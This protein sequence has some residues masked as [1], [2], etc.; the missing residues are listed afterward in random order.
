MPKI[1]I[2]MPYYNTEKELVLPCINSVLKQKFRDFEL[3]IVNDGS[4]KEHTDMISRTAAKDSRIKLINKPNSGASSTRNVG[5]D[6]ASGDYITFVDSDDI[7]MP[8]FLDNAYKTAVEFSADVVCGGVKP[9]KNLNIKIK[10]H[11]DPFIDVYDET[12][13]SEMKAAQ[14]GNVK[15]YDKDVFWGRV[16]VA[17]LIKRSFLGELRFNEN[18]EV[19]EDLIFNV[20]LFNR[21]HFKACVVYQIWYLYR[22]NPGSLSHV[23]RKNAI[24]KAEKTIEMIRPLMDLSNNIEYANFGNIIL[25]NL[26]DE[27][28]TYLY[29]ENTTV[30]DEERKHL[31]KHIYT[32][33]PWTFVYEKRYQKLARGKHKL[34][35][36]LY[37]FHLIFFAAKVRYLLS[38]KIRKKQ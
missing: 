35:G 7:V 19:S 16:T 22:Q 3:I 9:T 27:A 11:K 23:F 36:L 1:S 10:K 5:I 8:Y 32:S 14:S 30:T 38:K 21:P 37:R 29:H 28:A 17:K 20:A 13:R 12:R 34:A 18:A 25:G 31:I 15:R 4:S 2:I 24:E 33:R 26:V 6:A